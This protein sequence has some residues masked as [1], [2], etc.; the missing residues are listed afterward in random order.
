MGKAIHNTRRTRLFAAPMDMIITDD[1][2]KVEEETMTLKINFSQVE[3]R[4]I[5][6]SRIG[7]DTLEAFLSLF[8]H[9]NFATFQRSISR[10]RR[11]SRRT[12]S[13]SSS[14]TLLF[15][16]KSL[17]FAMAFPLCK[18][19]TSYQPLR[20]TMSEHHH[21][22]QQQQ[23]QQQQRNLSVTLFMNF[24]SLTDVKDHSRIDI[25][26]KEMET[27]LNELTEAGF[28]NAKNIYENGANS[29]VLATLVLSE[30][31]GM[32]LEKETE[33][34]GESVT[35]KPQ[36]AKLYENVG[37]GASAIKVKYES[38]RDC[39]VNSMVP[40]TSGCFNTTGTITL[41]SPTIE[42][43][44]ISYSYSIEEGTKN[45][46]TLKGFS[47]HA[48]RSG[49]MHED[50]KKFYDYYG[51]CDYANKWVMAAF[52]GTKTDLEN[53]N[54]DFGIYGLEGRSEAINT[55]ALS[56]N[57]WMH[58]VQKMEDSIVSCEKNCNGE[59]C[60]TRFISSWDEAVAY[61]FGSMENGREGSGNMPY[62]LANKVCKNFGTCGSL[63]LQQARANFDVMDQFLYGQEYLQ[64]GYCSAA[65]INKETIVKI[66]TVPLIQG[67]LHSAYMYDVMDEKTEEKQ[68][69]TATFAASIL[70]IVHACSPGNA[71]IIYNNLRVG[72]DNTN[73][74]FKEVK[75]ALESVYDCLGIDCVDV[76]GIVDGNSKNPDNPYVEGAERCKM[77]ETE[78]NSRLDDTGNEYNSSQSLEDTGNIEWIIGAS[79]SCVLLAAI[80]LAGYEYFFGV[81]WF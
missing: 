30:A 73:V 69:E 67:T 33:V 17:F 66:M 56:M 42:M 68:A 4:T 22:Q 46:R 75:V 23:Q 21:H 29:G 53:G 50:F 57:I 9:N 25:D 20:G 36:S 48:C 71:T 78:S 35:K 8:N 61:Y 51:E 59:E 7:R 34:S 81:R 37:K 80:L 6:V 63:F 44:N 1:D 54:A 79:V 2:G 64:N 62:S 26:R 47:T 77:V 15:A 31:L 28:I 40:F 65:R 13:G 12:C 16:M 32:E 45:S 41:A 18:C 11:V 74:S 14:E 58:I 70:P 55:A 27:Q 49:S 10:R 60:D 52:D 38:S 3:Q 43:T 24:Q 72:N 76:G 19:T 39:R 5:N